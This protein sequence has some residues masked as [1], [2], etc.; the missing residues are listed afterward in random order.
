[1]VQEVSG[2]YPPFKVP[3][4]VGDSKTPS[5]QWFSGPAE[6]ALQMVAIFAELTVMSNTHRQTTRL[7]SEVMA[8]I[9]SIA[10][11]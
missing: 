5:N 6:P 1:M 4:P 3:L 10:W 7:L 11:C 8:D 9:Y 2:T